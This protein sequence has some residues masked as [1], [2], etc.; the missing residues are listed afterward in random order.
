MSVRDRVASV[1]AQSTLESVEVPGF[2]TAYFRKL[3][4]AE[5]DRLMAVVNARHGGSLHNKAN[6]R[7]WLVCQVLCEEDGKRAFADGEE[8][9]IGL[10]PSNV[11]Q[12]MFDRFAAMNGMG[13][14]A[15]DEIEGNSEGMP[16]AASPSD[17]H[18]S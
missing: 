18:L 11:V 3:S 10:L 14:D 13:K 16:D 4:A 9:Q 15:V 8:G 12:F 5:F 1:A 17:S 7:S 2:G 6:W